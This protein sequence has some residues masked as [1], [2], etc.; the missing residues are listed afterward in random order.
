MSDEEVRYNVKMPQRLREDAKRN[1]DRGELADEVRKVFRRKAYGET[2]VDEPS[3]LEKAK[4]ELESVRERIDDKRRDRGRIENEIEAL[5]TRAAR[6][7]ERIESLEEEHNAIDQAIEMLE[8]M[9]QN[10]DRMYV[11]RIKNAADVDE[12]TA[13]EIQARL[14]D[15]NAELPDRAFKLPTP[16]EDADWIEATGYSST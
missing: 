9:L 1:T 10:G 8:N 13:K 2:A 11:A 12:D 5:E 15:R 3:E 16:H 7:E 14:K 6:L 4:A